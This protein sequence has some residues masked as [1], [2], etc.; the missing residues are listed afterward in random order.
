MWTIRQ[1]QLDA[2]ADDAF[3]GVVTRVARNLAVGFPEVELTL[4][5]GY[6]PWVREVLDAGVAL[7]LTLEESLLRFA[8]WHAQVGVASSV[9][10]RFPWAFD[11]LRAPGE[12]EE[13][14]VAAV[15]LRMQ[16]L[17]GDDDD[18]EG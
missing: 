6:L 8:E 12:R 1:A 9:A 3:E 15:D 5:G 18:G 2:F 11:V 4:G 7:D 14:R 10:E 13:D 16:G 17:D